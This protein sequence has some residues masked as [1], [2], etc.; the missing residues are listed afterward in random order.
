ME[1]TAFISFFA[2]VAIWLF[3]PS[4]SAAGDGVAA[5]SMEPELGSEE[6]G[7]AA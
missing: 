2:L 7:V 4:P 1:I 5:Y 3:L 6:A